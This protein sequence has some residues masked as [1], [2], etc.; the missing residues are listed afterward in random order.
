MYF[1]PTDGKY[2]YQHQRVIGELHREHNI[3]ATTVDVTATLTRDVRD[4]LEKLKQMDQPYVEETVE[5]DEGDFV[6]EG[7]T[8]ITEIDVKERGE[9]QVK[10]LTWLSPEVMKTPEYLLEVAGY[11]SDRWTLKTHGISNWGT[12]YNVEGKELHNYSIRLNMIPKT[13]DHL[14]VEDFIGVYDQVEYKELPV[15]K[16][17]NKIPVKERNKDNMLLWHI[18]DVHYGSVYSHGDRLIKHAQHI[19]DEYADGGY[20]HLKIAL[21]GDILHVDSFNETTT[22]GTQLKTSMSVYDMYRDA[23]QLLIDTIELVREYWAIEVVWTQGNHS[24][25][26]EFAMMDRVANDFKDCEDITFDVDERLRKADR[27]GTAMIGYGHGDLSKKQQTQW[28]QY[29]FSDIWGY[30]TSWTILQG[31]T[32]GLKVEAL[33]IENEGGTYIRTGPAMKELDDYEYSHGYHDAGPATLL[34]V[35]N[36]ERGFFKTE[37]IKYVIM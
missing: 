34:Y 16:T 20:H 36:K 28:L 35:V 24:R 11:P 5:S 21:T 22:R 14:G 2:K 31:H 25:I 10:L 27:W 4:Q 6:V 9:H 7:D 37:E 19:I 12:G 29:E 32:H 26:F 18:T 23:V 17:K 15:T 13:I 1:S 3:N 30:C 8:T 33:T